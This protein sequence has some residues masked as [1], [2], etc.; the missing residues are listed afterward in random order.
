MKLAISARNNSM[1]GPFEQRFGRASGF[2]IYDTESQTNTF[3]D[4]ANS[5]SLPQG[6]GIQSAQ[7]LSDHGVQALITGNIGPK[8]TQA[9]NAAGIDMYEFH[10]PTVREAIQAYDNGQLQSFSSSA[11]AG[12]RNRP[13]RLSGAGRRMGGRR[14]GSNRMGGRQGRGGGRGLANKN[15]RGPGRALGRGGRG[16][17][18]G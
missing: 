4:N 6:A 13:G 12:P 1:D 17:R 16:S 18:Q 9:L 15:S 10:G 8:A 11:P 7:K 3:L 2:I 14:G 5:R